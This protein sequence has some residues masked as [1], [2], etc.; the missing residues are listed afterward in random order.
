[1]NKSAQ[2]GPTLY[3]SLMVRSEGLKLTELDDD[4]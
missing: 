2:D 4:M 1:M 3:T